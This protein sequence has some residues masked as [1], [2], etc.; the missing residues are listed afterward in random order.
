[1]NMSL[2][3]INKAFE[4]KVRLGIM[5]ALMVNEEIDFTTLK[6]LL[7]LTDGNL[8]SH[9][10]S[11]EELGYIQSKKQFI[12]RKPNTTFQMTENGRAAFS[13]HLKALEDFLKI[14]LGN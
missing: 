8:A 5:S 12:G 7:D 14:S 10:R 9:T 4:S 3:H 2:E 13:E 1:M 11:L 6:S